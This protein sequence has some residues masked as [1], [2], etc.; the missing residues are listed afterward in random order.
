LN[1]HPHTQTQPQAK[2]PVAPSLR[3][4]ARALDAD[5]D[6][7]RLKAALGDMAVDGEGLPP[8]C[9]LTLRMGTALVQQGIGE[10]NLTP[11]DLAGLLVRGI[12]G[13]GA[14]DRSSFETLLEATYRSLAAEVKAAQ[15]QGQEQQGQQRLLG[16]EAYHG[17]FMELFRE[18]LAGLL[19][20]VQAQKHM[21]RSASS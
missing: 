19:D 10:R 16:Q 6:I 8:H 5:A 4:A 13:S 11:H 2:Q 17:R 7:A 3:A 1:P 21:L 20:G 9:L 12:D 14:G 18:G 15:Q